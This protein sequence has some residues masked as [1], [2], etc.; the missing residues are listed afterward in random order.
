MSNSNQRQADAPYFVYLLHCI[1]GSLYAGIAA[2][3]FA[4][5]ATHNKGK[6]A[7]YTR[8]RRPV[9]LVYLERHE[10][11]SQA[12]KREAQIKKL[13]RVSKDALVHNQAR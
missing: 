7:K 13:N 3:A 1:D 2:N 5:L 10:S 12:L 9:Q 4:R 11:K 8:S 6:G